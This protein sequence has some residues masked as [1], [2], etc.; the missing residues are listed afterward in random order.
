[1]FVSGVN[2][3]GNVA[4]VRFSARIL[5]A[6]FFVQ[7]PSEGFVRIRTTVVPPRSDGSVHLIH[8][9]K[10]KRPGQTVVYSV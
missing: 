6:V 1:M 9:I 10:G 3:K 4:E 2:A 5:V 8:Q 7:R